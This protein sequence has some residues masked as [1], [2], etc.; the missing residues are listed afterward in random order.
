MAKRKRQPR[1]R[2]KKPA[3]QATEPGVS[4]ISGTAPPP[5]H[6]WKPGQS[7]NPDG[8]PP[9]AGATIKEWA[10]LLVHQGVAEPE[11]R[12]IARDPKEHPA[13]RMAADQILGCFERGDMA[14]YVPVLEGTKTLADVREDG[15]DTGL[16]KKMTVKTRRIPGVPGVPEE[17]IERSIELADRRGEC[18]DRISDRTD[19]KPRQSVTV[20]NNAPVAVQIL[21]PLTAPPLPLAPDDANDPENPHR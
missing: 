2:P 13:R 4:P 15:M 12:R 17:I 20:E 8:R 11:L 9:A 7:G 18:F 19:G 6:R 5:E 14:D 3:V 10:N 16:V 21:T 1:K